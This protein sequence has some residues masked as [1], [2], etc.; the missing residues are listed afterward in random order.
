MARAA[1]SARGTGWLEISGCGH[2]RSERDALDVGIDPEEYSASRVRHGRGA[3]RVSQIQRAR[4]AHA[5]GRRHAVP[6]SILVFEG[7][8]EGISMKVSVTS[9]G[10]AG[11]IDVAASWTSPL[12]QA[13]SDRY[14]RRGVDVLADRRRSAFGT[15]IGEVGSS[16]EKHGFG[17]VRVTTV[18]HMHADADGSAGA[19]ADRVR[20]AELRGGRPYRCGDRR[21]SAAGQHQ[22]QEI[23]NCGVTSCGSRSSQRSRAGAAIMTVS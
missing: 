3:H 22:D 20:R 14:G 16:R 11:H 6:A 4:F 9:N 15:G 18:D 13:R 23:Q 12:R 7:R 8:A 17:D 5:G 1:G 10:L 21:R 19:A 2:G